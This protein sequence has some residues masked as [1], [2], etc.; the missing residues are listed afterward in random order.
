MENA[1]AEATT[2]NAVL[3]LLVLYSTTFLWYPEATSPAISP[4]TPVMPFPIACT[5]MSAVATR[6]GPSEPALVAFAPTI[7]RVTLIGRDICGYSVAY[8]IPSTAPPT[9]CPHMGE[10]KYIPTLDDSTTISVAG[11]LSLSVLF[12]T[13]LTGSSI[14]GICTSSKVLF[15]AVTTSLTGPLVFT[16]TYTGIF[17]SSPPPPNTLPN[18]SRRNIGN[19][20]IQNTISFRLIN[21][22]VI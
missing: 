8:K 9:I 22:F 1:R 11:L 19:T 21:A 7:S 14:C 12:N 6:A 15:R 5:S 2:A 18:I 20:N 3:I 10:V 17:C 4:A 16:Y 13:K